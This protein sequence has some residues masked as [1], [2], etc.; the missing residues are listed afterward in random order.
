MN[1]EIAV[2]KLSGVL[3]RMHLANSTESS[4]VMWLRRFAR[5]IAARSPQGTPEEK[6]ERF[7]TQLARQEV[8]ASTQNQAFQAILFFYKNVMGVEIGKVDALRAKRPEYVRTA[9]CSKAS[10]TWAATRPA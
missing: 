2:E 7:L 6:M 3:R 10:A 1:I 4:Y 5:F 9:P 8:S